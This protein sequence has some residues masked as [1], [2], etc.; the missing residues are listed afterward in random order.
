MRA[1]T[2]AGFL[3]VAVLGFADTGKAEAHDPFRAYAGYGNGPHDYLPHWHRTNTSYGPVYWYGNGLHDYLPHNHSVSPWGG[4]RSYSI[5]PIGPTKSYN[6][7]PGWGG[8]SGGYTPY[9]GNYIPYYN[10][11]PYYS[12]WG[13]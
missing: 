12:G 2:L 10:Y 13:W 7:F 9:Y 5:T 11:T 6:G 4:V 8:Y 1:F 3:A